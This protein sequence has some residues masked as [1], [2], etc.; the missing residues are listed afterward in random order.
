MITQ[1]WIDQYGFVLDDKLAVSGNAW[2]LSGLAVAVNLYGPS[3]DSVRRM[4]SMCR[5]S[6]SC[7]LLYRHP[8]KTNPDDGQQIDDMWAILFLMHKYRK[9]LAEEYL[10]YLE[11]NRWLAN[12]QDPES[13]NPEY[14]FDR[15]PMFAPLL[16]M[17]AG[18]HLTVYEKATVVLGLIYDAFD[19][20]DPDGIAR[21]QCRVALCQ[22]DSWVYW[23]PAKLWESRVKKKYERRG[24]AWGKFVGYSHPLSL[25]N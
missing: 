17:A 25:V 20:K 10:V 4:F 13:K 8:S 2:L 23:L 16:R 6:D 11:K 18:R 9:D 19:L 7:P 1:E 21:A 5:K 22:R 12:V 14:H 15:F 24:L 3:E